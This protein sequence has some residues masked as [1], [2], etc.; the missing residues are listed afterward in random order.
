[1]YVSLLSKPFTPLLFLFSL[2]LSFTAIEL[3]QS[4]AA[5]ELHHFALTSGLKD[6]TDM[7]PREIIFQVENPGRIEID[8]TWKP[9]NKK[10]TFTL[11][12]Q[13]SKAVVG[14]KEKSPLHL[15]Y[16]YNKDNF[17]NATHFGSSFRLQISQSL[18]RSISG[19]V[20]IVTPDK[21]DIDEEDHDITR[22]PYGTFMKEKN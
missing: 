20:T 12:D 2:I 4:S 10:L 22:G 18:F 17:E 9:G 21:K 7:R 6:S 3:K 16:D 8:A 14:K 1:M 5:E 19:N 13:T 11:Y 15:I